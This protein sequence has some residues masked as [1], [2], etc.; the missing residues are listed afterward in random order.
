M[1]RSRQRCARESR[2]TPLA[3]GTFSPR[4]RP[5]RTFSTGRGGACSGRIRALLRPF[6]MP[7]DDPLTLVDFFQLKGSERRAARDMNLTGLDFY[8][9]L[10]NG[11]RW[12]IELGDGI[13]ADVS[14]AI[15]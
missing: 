15:R 2:S 3:N 10:L 7:G 11:F 9:I 1:S 8:C 14:H 4:N 5:R 12:P 13:G 6:F